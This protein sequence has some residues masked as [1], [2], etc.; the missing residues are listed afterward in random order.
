VSGLKAISSLVGKGPLPK[1]SASKA[2]AR[3]EFTS[4]RSTGWS[5]GSGALNALAALVL[6]SSAICLA[7]GSGREISADEVIPNLHFELFRP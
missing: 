6:F 3:S 7:I 5:A 1:V 2:M 4:L